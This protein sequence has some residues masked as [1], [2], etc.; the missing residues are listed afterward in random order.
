MLSWKQK[1][2]INL[3]IMKKEAYCKAIVIRP[4]H[5]EA[6]GL[7]KVRV[8]FRGKF[9]KHMTASFINGN[10]EAADLKCGDEVWVHSGNGDAGPVIR[11]NL[12]VR[13]WVLIRY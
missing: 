3:V 9:S 6:S 8:R 11:H 13:L 2:I 12:M 10:P 7:I 5:R 1:Y 4:P